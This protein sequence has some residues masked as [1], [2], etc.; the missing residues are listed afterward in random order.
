M[1]GALIPEGYELDDTFPD[2][3]WVCPVRSC[4][5]ACKFRRNLGYHFIVSSILL[6]R[7]A[8]LDLTTII[9]SQTTHKTCSLNDNGDGTFSIMGLHNITAPRVVSKEPLD[10][11]E[12]PPHPPRL[13]P[14]ILDSHIA[15]RQKDSPMAPR[16][17]S[18]GTN[19]DASSNVSGAHL[20]DA[21]GP[22]WDW[23]HIRSVVPELSLSDGKAPEIA[24][25]LRLPKVRDLTVV[26]GTL[27]SDLNRKQITAF[28][29]QVVGEQ[30]PRACSECRRHDGP[31]DCCV[32]LPGDAAQR[33]YQWLA[34]SSR[35]CASCIAR[36][37]SSACSLRKLG[38][39]WERSS[40]QSLQAD[41]DEGAVDGG[42]GN[43]LTGRR[44]S[45]R[46]FLANGDVDEDGA[47][48]SDD[49]PHPPEPEP[50]PTRLVTLKLAR[51]V[52]NGR[53]ARESHV[54]AWD[55]NGAPESV[56][57]MEDWEMDEGRI[58]TAGEGMLSL[59]SP[60]SPP[61]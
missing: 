59:A 25:L 47:D 57:H 36:K 7:H 35:A 16:A 21:P 40:R 20:E 4:R 29:I 15:D 1:A 56:L 38:S 14:Y 46:L 37:N 43:D 44:R 5:L 51:S 60:P 41:I 42:W 17:A 58:N 11:N 9:L 3:P 27:P 31:F 8:G 19:K 13:P 50:R 24:M 30:N 6:R 48:E 54:A 22:L 55:G 23:D 61:F 52:A 39:A 2:R 18:P 28:A 26:P 32:S 53:A 34:T 33:L 49:E 10:P 12:P 45:A